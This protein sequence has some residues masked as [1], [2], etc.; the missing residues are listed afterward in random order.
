[1]FSNRLFYLLPVALLVLTACAPQSEV[2]TAALEPSLSGSVSLPT[3]TPTNLPSSTP[4]PLPEILPTAA[5]ITSFDERL[6]AT[7]NIAEHPLATANPFGFY[8]DEMVFAQ[9]FVWTK[10]ANGHVIQVDPATNS[11]VGALKVDTT[12]D[13]YHYCQGLGTDGENVWACSASG[14][15]DNRTID[16]VRIDPQT[17]S[18][19]E[20]VKVDKIFDQFDMPFLLNQIWV[21]SG[22]G[23]KL[24]GIDVTTNQPGPAIDL[25]SRCFQLTVM[26]NSLLATCALDNLVLEIDPEKREVTARAAV[27]GPRNISATEN[28]VWVLQDNAVIRLDPKSLTPVVAFTNL[29]RVG[30]MGDIFATDDAVWIRE[31]SGFLY[32]ID[33]A[34]NEFIE[35]IKPDQGLTGGGVL[36][37]SDSIWA[38][39][40]DDFLLIRL[41]L[42]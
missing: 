26:K 17:Q 7:V 38:T 24:I 22:N 41:S 33:P 2:P 11:M 30:S 20:T 34:S 14:D 8:P 1:M 32:R 16:V 3:S 29:P 36:V 12:T 27:Q 4:T 37:T 13:I 21:L 10:T 35:Q 31:E 5:S 42:K 9:G 18:I 19:V 40:V 15:A 6:L 23:D 39:A 28:G 25:G